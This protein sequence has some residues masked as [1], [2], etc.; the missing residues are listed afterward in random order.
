MLIEERNYEEITKKI[1]TLQTTVLEFERVTQIVCTTA[2]MTEFSN[3]ILPFSYENL[4]SK[5]S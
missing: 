5:L 1:I 2:I 3:N 4:I